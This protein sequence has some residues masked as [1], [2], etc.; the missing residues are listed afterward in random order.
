M[1]FIRSIFFFLVLNRLVNFY[2]RYGIGFC[3]HFTFLIANCM[4]ANN[5]TSGWKCVVVYSLQL[6]KI[7]YNFNTNIYWIY[8]NMN[9]N[10]YTNY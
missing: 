8:F 3:M 10:M 5:K 1:V 4:C 6:Q 7:Q 2:A 9:R